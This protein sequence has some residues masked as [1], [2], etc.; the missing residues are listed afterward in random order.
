MRRL[1]ILATIVLMA[2]AT[3]PFAADSQCLLP[4]SPKIC[5]I[6]TAYIADVDTACSKLDNDKL[7]SALL[8]DIREKFFQDLEST[9]VYPCKE[10]YIDLMTAGGT[11][12]SW[13]NKILWG[14]QSE[15]WR[16]Q[17]DTIA[18][19]KSERKKALDNLKSFCR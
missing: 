6:I 13:S 4:L 5:G 18:F 1:V 12:N 8:E 10:H 19:W 15:F 11:Y 9:L 14:L 16:S 2:L 3:A 17:T 7:R